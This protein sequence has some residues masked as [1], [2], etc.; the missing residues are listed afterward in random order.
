M[1]SKNFLKIV[2]S[3]FHQLNGN[4]VLILNF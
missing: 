2:A 3:L 1:K 4:P